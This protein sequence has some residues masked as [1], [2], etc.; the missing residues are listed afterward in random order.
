MK[1]IQIN[2]DN[3]AS[4]AIGS[5]NWD[6]ATDN[7]LNMAHS[8]LLPF[9]Q[10]HSAKTLANALLERLQTHLATELHY[11][12]TGKNSDGLGE[13][14]SAKTFRTRFVEMGGRLR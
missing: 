9:L 3:P 1:H 8:Q 11:V 2:R 10:F 13:Y 7:V 4:R 5:D 6:R 12:R 14:T